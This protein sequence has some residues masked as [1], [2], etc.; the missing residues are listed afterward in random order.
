MTTLGYFNY[1]PLN[2][3]R[4][5]GFS[6]LC[7]RSEYARFSNR[8]EYPMSI[9]LSLSPVKVMCRQT[10]NENPLDDE[11]CNNGDQLTMHNA[12]WYDTPGV[13]RGMN[14]PDSVYDT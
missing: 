8:L 10:R 7:S 9:V 1:V 2:K 4:K 12:H 5:R 14:E 6:T 13:N 3:E 11:L